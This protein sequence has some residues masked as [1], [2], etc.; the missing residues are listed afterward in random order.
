MASKSKKSGA[1]PQENVTLGPTV[2]EGEHVF[3]VCLTFRT[4]NKTTLYSEAQNIYQNNLRHG[5]AVSKNPWLTRDV[6]LLLFRWPTS[7]PAS[8]TRC[9][10]ELVSNS[11][12]MHAGAEHATMRTTWSSTCYLMQLVE[13]LLSAVRARH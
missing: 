11:V 9:G 8:M 7:S 4:L 6:F 1:A 10:G 2:R 12:D 13:M 3:G 5:T